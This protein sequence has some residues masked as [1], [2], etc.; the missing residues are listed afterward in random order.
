MKAPYQKAGVWPHG[1]CL[2]RVAEGNPA[3]VGGCRWLDVG[4]HGAQVRKEACF[5]LFGQTVCRRLHQIFWRGRGRRR[6][7]HSEGHHEE[8]E[9]R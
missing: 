5:L 1:A 9:R 7:S 6:G 8:A 4:S 2:R 3:I